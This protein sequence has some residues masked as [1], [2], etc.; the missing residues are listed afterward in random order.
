MAEVGGEVAAGVGSSANL[1]HAIRRKRKATDR[2]HPAPS[3]IGELIIPEVLRQTADQRDFLL[4]DSGR[5]DPNRM[6]IFSTDQFL[7]S[8]HDS[9]HWMCDCTFKVAP[10]LFYQVFTVH[11]LIRNNLLPCIFVLMPN[12]Q[13]VTYSEMW[14]AIKSM[15]SGLA[16]ISVQIDFE[17]ASKAALVEEHFLKRIYTAVTFTWDNRSG[18]RSRETDCNSCMCKMSILGWQ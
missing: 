16:P 1:R 8:L 11:T 9:K 15:N 13:Q 3:N 6:L 2:Y 14:T 10:S 18:E 12:K 4:Y 5:E 17:L 7:Q